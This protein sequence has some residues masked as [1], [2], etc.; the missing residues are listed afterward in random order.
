MSTF[1]YFSVDEMVCIC[2]VPGKCACKM[3]GSCR[4][5]EVMFV[6]EPIG[7]IP[8]LVQKE[9]MAG[10][11]TIHLCISLASR[12][13][14]SCIYQGLSY[15]FLLEILKSLAEKIYIVWMQKC[16]MLSYKKLENI[17]SPKYVHGAKV[18]F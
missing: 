4:Y 16:V 1:W 2:N 6:I 12:T 5:S 15:I 11:S 7:G 10:R 18:L 17:L 14:L 3:L 8:V 9:K 13:A